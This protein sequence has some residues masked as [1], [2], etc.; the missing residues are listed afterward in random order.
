MLHLAEGICY[1]VDRL[2]K[3]LYIMSVT[4][5]KTMKGCWPIFLLTSG[6]FL[7]ISGAIYSIVKKRIDV[8]SGALISLGA[9]S[10]IIGLILLP[11][12]KSF[13]K[14]IVS[15]KLQNQNE[16]LND[17]TDDTDNKLDDGASNW[18]TPRTPTEK[19]PDF[20]I[21][22]IPKTDQEIRNMIVDP[23][24]KFYFFPAFFIE[25]D[26]LLNLPNCK[27]DANRLRLTRG[28]FGEK[29]EFNLCII[30]VIEPAR[31]V[32]MMIL[33]DL[34]CAHALKNKGI[35]EST[36]HIQL[37][38]NAELVS[39]IEE[40]GLFADLENIQRLEN[41]RLRMIE[42][43]RSYCKDPSVSDE[44]IC[45]A[46][47]LSGFKSD[48]EK[49]DNEKFTEIVRSRIENIN[50]L[51]SYSMAFGPGAGYHITI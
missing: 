25:Y 21:R 24:L 40:G 22:R 8:L 49:V 44:A 46:L 3:V 2:I 18:Y 33:I 43:G 28:V 32:A 16:I 45:Q 5:L 50:S 29:D 23:G 39:S 20:T 14:S 34:N 11:K 30:G 41:I 13:F 42:R 26:D 48:W 36:L 31:A 1:S 35:N 6:F 9:L 12:I 27:D 51:P 47:G 15:S 38:E 10:L 17:R 7:L 19:I 4:R 37:K